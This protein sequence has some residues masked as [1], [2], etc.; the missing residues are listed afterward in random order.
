VGLRA[1]TLF[2]RFA[3]LYALAVFLDPAE[4]ALYGLVYATVGYGLLVVGFDFNVFSVREFIGS[5]GEDRVRVARNYGAFI[6]CAQAI[7][8][9]LSLLLFSADLLPWGVAGWFMMLL[10]AEHISQEVG[11][12]LIADSRPLT[13]ALIQFLRWGAWVMVVIPVMWLRPEARDLLTVFAGWALGSGASCVA[14]L[15]SLR[16]NVR[17]LRGRV[18]WQWVWAGMKTAA[19][20]FVSTLCWRAINVLD[21]YW[22]EDLGGAE[23]LAA[24]VL[25]AGFANVIIG[26]L[27]A[28]VFSFSYP[29]MVEASARKDDV[30]FS[31]SMRRMR[32]QTIWLT[33][34]LSAAI[35]ILAKPV[36]GHVGKEAYV[37]HYPILVWAVLGVAC[38]SFSM[39]PHFALYAWRQDVPIIASQVLCLP[40]FIAMAFALTAWFGAYAV[41]MAASFT[42]L[43]VMLFKEAWYNRFQ[44][45]QRS[46]T[47]GLGAPLR[48]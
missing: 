44:R 9:P 25:Y 20:F 18:D 31:R 34:A 15:L 12:V 2:A 13:A 32:I 8:L 4:V 16:L 6:I 48:R 42:F 7:G 19:L 33:L 23:V 27:D 46:T 11:R 30:A 40:F 36:L 28:A 26:F 45:R 47:M 1:I 21:R 24:Y 41:P 35:L 39:V 14:G 5:S 38:F 10:A 37:G 22:I 3:L 29:Q 17:A 43:S